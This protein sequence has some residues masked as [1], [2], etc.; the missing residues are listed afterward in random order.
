MPRNQFKVQKAPHYFPK[1]ALKYIESKHTLTKNGKYYVCAEGQ[2]ARCKNDFEK[3]IERET[4]E[5]S[6]SRLAD[7][8]R[9]PKQHQRTIDN[10][11]RE[12]LHFQ[13][14]Y[15]IDHDEPN[16]VL[17]ATLDKI[18]KDIELKKPRAWAS[19]MATAKEAFLK[20]MKKNTMEIVSSMILG[21]VMTFFSERVT[22]TEM[23]RTLAFLADEVLISN[24]GEIVKVKLNTIGSYIYLYV[25]KRIPT[26]GE[27]IR[28]KLEY[29]NFDRLDLKSIAEKVKKGEL[30]DIIPHD[31]FN[32]AYGTLSISRYLIASTRNIKPE[33]LLVALLVLENSAFVNVIVNARRLTRGY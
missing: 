20:H 31:P 8:L 14:D 6:F 33:N 22:E 7:H 3:R 19:D 16:E 21:G 26:F 17:D 2:K 4:L 12:V 10:I 15:I 24:D 32:T 29:R 5:R 25:K 27:K 11:L 9:I 1:G 30:D 13:V 23:G 18:R 28:S